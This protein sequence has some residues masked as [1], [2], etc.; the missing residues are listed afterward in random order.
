[1]VRRFLGGWAILPGGT[2]GENPWS[3]CLDRFRMEKPVVHL[4]SSLEAPF[5]QLQ[6]EAT[7]SSAS[8]RAPIAADQPSA[9][10]SAATRCRAPSRS[11]TV[12]PAAWYVPKFYRELSPVLQ[13]LVVGGVSPNH[14]MQP[15]PQTVIKFA[16]ANLP[17]VWVAADAGC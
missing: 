4:S 12:A 13:S 5:V 9:Q 14:C 7:R 8:S 2:D 11:G 15:T 10:L 17:P 16:C 3:V 1:M 6:R